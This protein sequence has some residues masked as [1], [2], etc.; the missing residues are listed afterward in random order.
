MVNNMNLKKLYLSGIL[1]LAIAS[2]NSPI[3]TGTGNSGH[4]TSTNLHD[5]EN[6]NIDNTLQESQRNLGQGPQVNVGCIANAN[7]LS[8]GSELLAGAI[9]CD[10]ENNSVTPSFPPVNPNNL[11]IPLPSGIVPPIP[12][13]TPSIGVP[14]PVSTPT[15]SATPTPSP[16]PSPDPAFL[17]V[18]FIFDGG[19]SVNDFIADVKTS[20]QNFVDQLQSQS[21]SPTFSLAA[22]AING[23]GPYKDQIDA[24]TLLVNAT[25]NVN[26]IKTEINSFQNVN[27]TSQDTFSS[28]V[29]TVTNP[30]VG[31]NEPDVP[32][33]SMNG[34]QV[35]PMVQI[36]I[37]DHQPEQ[38]V[39]FFTGFT[40]TIQGYSVQREQAVANYLA[41]QGNVRT[42]VIAEPNHFDKYDSI[43]AATGGSMLSSFNQMLTQDLT[44]LLVP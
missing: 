12:S 4:N 41:S 18:V 33:R 20:L 32:S 7:A 39:G 42:F 44:S 40:T 3:I 9:N 11:P 35:A 6:V 27:G 13:S 2:C 23:N 14:P 43:T 28:L 24:T 30:T 21:F 10:N 26:V 34:S 19:G 36:L 29:E 15:P 5:T 31:T 37:T 38:Q 1:T 22:S 17:D 25:N 8:E 16:T